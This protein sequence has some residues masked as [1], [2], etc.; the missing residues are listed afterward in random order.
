[1]CVFVCVCVCVCVCICI[2]ICDITCQSI[3]SEKYTL[4]N[5][6]YFFLLSNISELNNYFVY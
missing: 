5:D 4:A 6:I 3:Y 2:C 1:M